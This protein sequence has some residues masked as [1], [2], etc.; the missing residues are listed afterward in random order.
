MIRSDD[1]QRAMPLFWACEFSEPGRQDLV[2]TFVEISL[3]MPKGGLPRVLHRGRSRPR[4]P[5]PPSYGS[6]AHAG[7]SRADDRIVP[8]EA[9]RWVA[10][11]IP[12]AE[13][14]A[15]KGCGHLPAFTAPDEV[16][17]VIRTFLTRSPTCV[18]YPITSWS[19]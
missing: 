1:Y 6:C 19:S 4:Y 11:Q 3:E 14:H 16:V 5:T 17:K 7:P 12:G 15:F 8:V 13:F 2:D 18:K 9:G 10:Q